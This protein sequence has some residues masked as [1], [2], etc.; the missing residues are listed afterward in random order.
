M[1]DQEF[2]PDD[3]RA[4]RAALDAFIDGSTRAAVP[5]MGSFAELQEKRAAHLSDAGARLEERLGED[6][7]RVMDLRQSF[8]AADGLR[9][10]LRET[11]ARDSRIPRLEALQWMVLGRVL[12]R[13][14]EPATG[15]TVRVFDRDRQYDDLLGVTTTDEYGDFAVVYHERD[16]AEPGED[17]P[18]LYVMVEDREGNQVY[19]SRDGLRFEAGRAEYFQIILDEQ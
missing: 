11:A 8:L 17:L 15:M 13:A 18:E 19:S 3:V 9:R 6:H 14:G 5:M 4:V 7:P 10:S 1:S 16:F 12:D 2:T